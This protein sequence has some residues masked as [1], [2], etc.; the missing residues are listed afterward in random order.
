MHRLPTLLATSAPFFRH[1]PLGCGGAFPP[2]WGIGGLMRRPDP[3]KL[4]GLVPTRQYQINPA[5]PAPR[6]GWR[7]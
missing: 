4:E 1:A 7:W 6:P 5:P 3:E 2:R